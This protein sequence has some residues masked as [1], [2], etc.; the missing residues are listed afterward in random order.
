VEAAE[1]LRLLDNSGEGESRDAVLA[2][3]LTGK[4]TVFTSENSFMICSLIQNGDTLE[5]HIWIGCGK[6]KE[7]CGELG[8]QAEQWAKLN[9]ATLCTVRGRKGWQRVL[10]DFHVTENGK[11]KRSI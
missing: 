4:A 8:R 5:G 3:L 11:L 7:L 1:A 9:G 10:R 6:M 2:E